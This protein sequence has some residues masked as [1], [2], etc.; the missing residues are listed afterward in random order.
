MTAL[1][2]GALL[3]M[4]EVGPTQDAILIGIVTGGMTTLSVNYLDRWFKK[5]KK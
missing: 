1:I 4:W 2:I 5:K 3:S